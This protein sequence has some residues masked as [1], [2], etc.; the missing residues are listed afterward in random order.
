MKLF[1]FTLKDKK[2]LSMSAFTYLTSETIK[3]HH[4]VSQNT[5]VGLQLLCYFDNACCDFFFYL[6]LPQ[7]SFYIL[8]PVFM[9]NRS[10]GSHM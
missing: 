10:C 6:L 7:F 9:K 1:S 5:S 4:N 3:T 8:G 2:E